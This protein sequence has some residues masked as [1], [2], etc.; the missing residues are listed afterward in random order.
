MPKIHGVPT[1]GWIAIARTARGGV[2]S[3]GRRME[4]MSSRLHLDAPVRG[5]HALVHAR[6]LGRER[7]PDAERQAARVL[8]PCPL[9]HRRPG[10]R[11]RFEQPGAVAA[12]DVQH[13]PE[14]R[15]ERLAEIARAL[16][17]AVHR[18]EALEEPDVPSVLPL[19]R[20]RHPFLARHPSLSAHSRLDPT[21]FGEWPDQDSLT[22]RPGPS[23]TRGVARSLRSG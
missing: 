17:R 23:A 18:V 11:M 4:A 19:H 12:Q 16:D 7:S 22:R 15:I 13:H 3:A 2:T 21:T 20:R 14:R 10:L 6:R 1:F 5:E 9:H 8:R